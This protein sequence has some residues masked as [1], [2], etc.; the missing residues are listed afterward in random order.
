MNKGNENLTNKPLLTTIELF[1]GIGA[2][3]KGIDKTELFNSDVIATSDL[4]KEVVV[5]YAAIHCGLTN[6]MINSYENYPS[7][8]EMVEE[9]TKKRLGYD[10]KKDKPYDWEKLS[11]KKDKTKGIEKYWLADKLSHN[12]GDITQIDKLP[13][14][15]LLTP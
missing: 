6:E 4:D 3:K 12:L 13:T 7:K 9:L 1:S 2:Q 10:F 5:S 15:D 14:C 11:K 8:E